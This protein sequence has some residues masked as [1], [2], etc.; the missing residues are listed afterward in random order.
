MFFQNTP[1]LFLSR[2][3]LLSVAFLGGLLS[4]TGRASD[5]A[6]PGKP[7]I[8]LILVDDMG[9]GDIAPFYP[10]TKNRTPHLDKMAAE[11][12]KLTSFYS[13]PTCTPSR[14][15]FMTGCYAQRVGL[16]RVIFPGSSIGL[17]AKEHTVA[18]L[19]KTNGYATFAIGKW[20]LGD[21][22]GFLPVHRGFEH[23]LG[24]PYSN[25]MGGEWDGVSNVPPVQRK[26]PLPLVQDDKVIE[27]LKPDDQNFLT[28]RY[29]KA[30]E[31]FI[32]DHQAKPFFLYLAHTAVHYPIHP[33]ANFRGHSQNGL[34]GDW[35]EEVD[36]STGRI[37]DLLKKLNL[38]KNTLV[39]FTS[40]NGPWLSKGSDAGIAGP[41][42][43]GKKST[44][45]GGLRE[46]TIAWWPGHI[47]PGTTNDAVCANI[48]VLPTFVK[49][50]GGSIPTD[51]KID[52][53]NIM[54]LLMGET[55]ESPHEA[56]YYYRF[57][58][59]QGVRSGPWKLRL[60]GDSKTGHVDEAGDNSEKGTPTLYNLDNDIG[61]KMDVAAAHPDIV[62]K[63]KKLADQMI[64]DLGSTSKEGEKIKSPGRRNPD[65]VAH[66]KV[67]LMEAKAP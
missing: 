20:H 54:P 47:A 6:G 39:L 40:D 7:N 35:V 14:A 8:I 41:L 22:P 25:D 51:N 5:E 38:D 23:Y 63:L 31:K 11:G 2:S 4:G 34:F 37:L 45:E 27:T 44:W 61:E 15:Q 48:D 58:E 64:A 30:A 57:S 26:P 18:E 9:Y 42:R 62:A 46:P 32:T 53:L 36:A 52:G 65:E 55:K 50:A 49:L 21:Q 29:T 67:L 10:M 56:F 60:V 16:P 1:S 28:E 17:S 24:L 13:S 12:M 19:L 66:P 3:L 43:G 33:G 59:L